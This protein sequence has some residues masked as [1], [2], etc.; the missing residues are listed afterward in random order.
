M[1]HMISDIYSG[2]SCSY[3]L[4]YKAHFRKNIAF[5]IFL[6][7]CYL[8]SAALQLACNYM[9][10]KGKIT[11]LCYND[12]RETSRFTICAECDEEKQQD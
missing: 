7:R 3:R 6:L 10:Y 4:S 5:I 12:E 11:T 2:I 1:L 8:L 9:V